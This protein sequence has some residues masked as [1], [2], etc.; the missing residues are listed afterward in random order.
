VVFGVLLMGGVARAHPSSNL[1]VNYHD[2]L[3]VFPERIELRSIVDSVEIPTLQDRDVAD[4]RK[5]CAERAKSLTAM[6]GERQL[7]FEVHD[8]DV[9]RPAGEAGLPTMRSTCEYTAVLPV[10]GEVEVTFGD[11]YLEDRPG[12]REI[13][14]VGVDMP[15]SGAPAESIT[16]ELRAYPD[17]LLSSPLDVR[18]VRFAARPG[19]G[20][21]V[22]PPGAVGEA[23]KAAAGLV[24][25]LTPVVGIGAV[26][27]SL[28]LGASHAALPG[29]GKPGW[30]P[31]WRVRG[32]PAATH[33][34][35]APRSPSPTRRVSWCWGCCSAR[36]A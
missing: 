25:D 11:S 27:L 18:A 7:R 31:I 14:V 29:H 15:V 3:R 22:T 12:W 13:T 30:P 34:S 20:T 8:A 24:G 1:S 21:V 10:R 4:A 36:P 32:V 19:G 35:S 28:V 2:G 6:A 5:R 17:D 23:A 9:V 16:N 33:S 26:L